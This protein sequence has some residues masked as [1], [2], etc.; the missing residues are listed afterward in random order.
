MVTAVNV[1]ALGT[2]TAQEAGMTA[3]RT[4]LAV[5]LA[6]ALLASAVAATALLARRSHGNP[7]MPV[8]GPPEEPTEHGQ[9]GA[10]HGEQPVGLH[11]RP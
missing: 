5:P 10:R 11:D 1:A 2:A 6:A 9:A 3:L 8:A 4:A 7:K